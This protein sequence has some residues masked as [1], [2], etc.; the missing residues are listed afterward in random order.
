M[1]RSRVSEADRLR[2]LHA[3][4][5]LDTPPSP[6][7]DAITRAAA[8]LLGSPIALVSLVDRDRQWFKSHH[9]L[10]VT[11]TP[12]SVSFC[13]RAIAASDEP[14][15]VPDATADVRFADNPLVTGELGLRA[16]AGAPLHG[17]AGALLGTLCTL[18]REPREFTQADVSALKALARWAELEVAL[19]ALGI[20]DPMALLEGIT[21]DGPMGAVRH[22]YWDLAP[23][24]LLLL[25]QD[26]LVVDAN[27][28]LLT[29]LGV[30]QGDV[31]G[32]PMAGLGG[33]GD[34]A[35]VRAA[36]SEALAEGH[37]ELAYSVSAANGTALPL[38]WHVVRDEGLVFACGRLGPIGH[39]DSARAPT[40]TRSETDR[41]LQEAVRRMAAV[42]TAQEDLRRSLAHLQ[43]LRERPSSP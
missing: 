17:P 34:T 6:E 33:T 25:D 8:D 14:M 13:S 36:I 39:R 23:D 12:R 21:G 4:G 40:S 30:E 27:Q 5:L 1:D 38:L 15:V 41:A 16:Y 31:V 11:Q 37:S 3:T 20:V 28:F 9:G 19:H 24:P 42:E 7:F 10:D 18:D 26:G 29:L 22:R 32:Q 35:A 43:R 2:A